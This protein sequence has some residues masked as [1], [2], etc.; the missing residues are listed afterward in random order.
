MGTSNP[1]GL[2][3]H[4]QLSYC[5]RAVQFRTGHLR[6]AISRPIRDLQHKGK[7]QIVKSHFQHLKPYNNHNHQFDGLQCPNGTY[8]N[9]NWSVNSLD[10]TCGNNGQFEMPSPFPKCDQR[11]TCQVGSSRLKCLMWLGRKT[12]ARELSRRRGKLHLLMLS[13]SL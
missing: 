1:P 5:G 7:E 10:L 9:T 4:L 12:G 6:G 11:P 8:L 2:C 3:R 13:E